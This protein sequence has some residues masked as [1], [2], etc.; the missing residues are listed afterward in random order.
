MNKLRQ[1]LKTLFKRNQ[2]K[3][4]V[5]I[6]STIFLLFANFGQ[7]KEV[8]NM[9]EK[10]ADSQAEYI[11]LEEKISVLQDEFDTYKE[12][13]KVY[14]QEGKDIIEKRE[15]IIKTAEEAIE[16]L[17]KNKTRESLDSAKKATE[18][19]ENNDKKEKMLTRINL[20]ESQIQEK[21][22]KEVEKKL[23]SDIEEAVKK[24]EA[25]QTRENMQAATDKLGGL[26]DNGKRE[27]YQKR[28]DAVNQAIVSREASQ[29]AQQAAEQQQEVQ[30]FAQTPSQNT[31][32]ANCTAVRA[33]GAAPIHAGQ[34]GYSRKL[35][36]DG[37]GVGCE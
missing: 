30:Q 20:V 25:D 28:I 27:Q 22:K 23:L 32:Y 31:F 13:N 21:E 18:P 6:I 29:Q 15:E 4:I 5:P 33:A 12:E 16:K 26:S 8:N 36:R 34:P 24:M 10:L 9:K 11:L 3:V 35:D 2:L 17:E 1:K 37:D 19:L 14:I 7:S